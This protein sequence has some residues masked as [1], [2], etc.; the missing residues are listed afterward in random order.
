M[1]EGIVP[2]ASSSPFRS[3]VPVLI[4]CRCLSIISLLSPQSRS[5]YSPG[6][7]HSPSLG[8]RPK[9]KPVWAKTLGRTPVSSISFLHTPAF[10]SSISEATFHLRTMLVCPKGCRLTSSAGVRCSSGS[11]SCVLCPCDVVR[12]LI[13]VQN[14]ECRFQSYFHAIFVRLRAFVWCLGAP[15]L[16]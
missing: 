11:K 14:S 12:D 3:A 1:P 9:G 10:D 13:S 2:S 6:A 7:L 4:F 5:F 8:A 16:S 15:H